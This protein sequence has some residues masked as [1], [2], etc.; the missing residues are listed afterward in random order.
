MDKN[1]F[2]FSGLIR[3]TLFHGCWLCMLL[4]SFIP[5]IAIDYTVPYYPWKIDSCDINNDGYNDLIILATGGLSYLQNNGDG[6]F[7]PYELIIPGDVMIVACCQL[8]NVAGDDIVVLRC[9]SG[10]EPIQYEYYYNGNFTEPFIVPFTGNYT[11]H[12][13]F[14]YAHGDFNNDGLQD[15]VLTGF[16]E[17]S[18]NRVFWCYMYN[19]GNGHFS[20]PTYIQCVYSAYSALAVGDFNEDN[21]DDVAFTISSIQIYYSTG[22][23]FYNYEALPASH[24]GGILAIDFDQDGDKDL[25]TN[26]WEGGSINHH[27]YLE[28][29]PGNGFVIHESYYE[30][31]MGTI[32]SADLNN[33][34][35]PDIVSTPGGSA[36]GVFINLHNWTME[37]YAVTFPYYGEYR[38][39]SCLD[40]FNGDPFCDIAIAR[41]TAPENNLTILYNDGTGNF[42]QTPVSIHDEVIPSITNRIQCYP[43]PCVDVVTF[44]VDSAEPNA[45]YAIYNI[46]GQV[47]RR[48]LFQGQECRW[49]LTDDNG[50]KLGSG[51]YLVRS[52]NQQDDQVSK[53]ILL[54]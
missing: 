1:H 49:D 7:A 54:K 18:T 42:F 53:F 10:D 5:L 52:R 44:K 27:Y 40:L 4:L 35:Y 38:Q 3:S 32:Y 8:D 26:A 11:L 37:Q 25:V 24:C 39:Y 43:N 22:T 19:L 23:G 15:I 21:L 51:I 46:K 28:N 14:K 13:T 50:L 33:D 9:Y 2:R 30:H 31:Y 29:V 41:D 48:L 36:F 16:V 34:S 47:V 17:I 20:A 12:H 45:A 6:T